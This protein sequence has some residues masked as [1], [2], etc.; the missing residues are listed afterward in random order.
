VTNSKWLGVVDQVERRDRTRIFP[1]EQEKRFLI[2]LEK[3]ARM[4]FDIVIYPPLHAR[5]LHR[6]KKR[7]IVFGNE[8]DI[9]ILARTDRIVQDSFRHP[10]WK[11]CK[12]LYTLMPWQDKKVLWERNEGTVT[13]CEGA[14][15]PCPGAGWSS[16]SLF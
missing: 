6:F 3:E 11:F 7:R 12:T 16:A 14:F 15:E 8:R 13:C 5:F 2:Q 4:E 1:I 10:A 9:L